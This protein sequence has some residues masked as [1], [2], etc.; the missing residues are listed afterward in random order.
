M[1]ANGENTF[2]VQHLSRTPPDPALFTVPSD[3]TVTDE[4]GAFT[5]HFPGR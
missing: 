1:P 5:I 4:A 2:R 3:Y